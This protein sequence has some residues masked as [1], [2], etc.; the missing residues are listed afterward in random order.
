MLNNI[1]KLLIIAVFIAVFI[2]VMYRIDALENRVSSL[3][4][5][6]TTALDRQNNI[7]EA[8]LIDLGQRRVKR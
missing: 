5:E 2:A 4:T 6:I 7:N 8:V 3:T 1:R